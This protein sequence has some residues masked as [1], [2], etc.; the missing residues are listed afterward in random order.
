[1]ERLAALAVVGLLLA[2]GISLPLWS[3]GAQTTSNETRMSPSKDPFPRLPAA[4]HLFVVPVPT[5]ANESTRLTLLSIQGLVNRNRAELYLDFDGEVANPSSL[6]SFLVPRY[7]LTVDVVDIAWVYSR[8]L[9]SLS[10][11][12]VYDPSRPES[13]NVVTVLSSLRNAA[14]AGPDT[15]PSLRAAYGLPVL[16]DYR[17][18]DWASLDAIG[19]TDRALRDLYPSTDGN[20]LAILPPDRLVLRDYLIATR[21]FVFH[22]RQ[23]LLATPAERASTQRV[24]AAAPRGI[25]I[26]GWFETPTL[27]EEN[28]FIQVASSYGKFLLGTQAVP[29]LSV[30][31]T[32]GRDE[33]RRPPAP[34]DPRPPLEDKTYAVV[35]V[36]DGDNVDFVAGRMR[37]L[38]AQPERGAFPL[39]WSL[40]PLLAGLAPPLLDFYYESASPLDRFVAGPS[41][42]GY[43]YPDYLGPGDLEP[44]LAFTR[45]YLNATGLDVVWLLNAFRASEIPYGRE[46]LSAYADVLRPRGLVLDYDDQPKTEDAWIA[47]GTSAAAPVIRSTHLWTTRDNFLGKVEAA[48][49]AQGPGP[50]FL[51][52]TVYTFRFDLR[53]AAEILAALRER[54]HGALEVVT[55]AQLFALLEADFVRRA[56]AQLA[57]MRSHVVAA[58]FL[59]PILATAEDRL[60]APGPGADDTSRAYAAYLA[61]RDLQEAAFLEAVLVLGLAVVAVAAVPWALRR[62]WAAPPRLPPREVQVLLSV[63]AALALFLFALRTALEANFWSYPWVVLGMALAG[64]GRPLRRRLDRTYPTS[65]VTATA[66][67]DLVLIAL[68]LVTNVAFGLAALGTVAAVD[69]ILVRGRPSARTVVLSIALGFSLGSL[70][71]ITPLSFAVLTALLLIPLRPLSRATVPEEIPAE[72]RVLPLGFLLTLPLAASFAVASTYSLGLRLG[73]SG[74][75]LLPMAV[76]VLVLGAL[77]GLLAARPLSSADPRIVQVVSFAAASASAA[78]VALLH[79]TI[80]MALALLGAVACLVLGAE[81]TLR[82]HMA[83]GGS[84]AAAATATVPWIPFLVLFLRMP[85]VAFSLAL[86]PLPEALEYALYAPEWL[87][88][89]VAA[90]SA[91]VALRAP[92]RKGYHPPTAVGGRGSP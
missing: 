60:R 85:P 86:V 32:L 75:L 55:P 65:A 62:R 69:G 13:V 88:A 29:N 68:A 6:L 71:D 26:L 3:A 79:G 38:W 53:D 33:V 19:A 41:G 77:A 1:V 25:P 39:A 57:A 73:L 61:S 54:T 89:L 47:A 56:E 14:I 78:L 80:P 64:L 18:S 84:A 10:G 12:V 30:L 5:S 82:R 16:L 40:S 59:G 7:G 15:A 8:Y 9:P 35:A 2:A 90:A 66:T 83:R 31:T 51:W 81:A 24:L 42:A 46:T 4:S 45:R 58:T 76:V 11:L 49:A 36:P 37:A 28:D 21:T 44:Y 74:G 91:V 92:S 34:P 22:N 67:L 70:L 87:L 72:T 43:L 17:T 48:M 50:R 23:G 20:L 27:T 63:T 52:I